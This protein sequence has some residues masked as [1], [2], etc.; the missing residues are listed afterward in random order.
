MQSQQSS[1][2]YVDPKSNVVDYDGSP[3]LAEEYEERVW[4]GFQKDEKASYAAK[5]KNALH[6]RAWTLR[7]RKP[8]IAAQKLSQI[9][10][11][12]PSAN[13]GPKAAVQLVVK[14]V[15]SACEKVAPLL[16]TQTFEDYF[17]DK[18]RRKL[19][20]SIQD[21]ISRREGE[22]E[23]LSALTQGHT[24]LSTDLQAFL[25]LRN[26]GV[27]PSQHRAILGQ[28]GNEYDWDKIVEAMLIQ[29]DGGEEPQGKG[30]K[31]N[32]KSR[33]QSNYSPGGKRSWA[34]P[35]EEE[36]SSYEGETDEIYAVEDW[37]EEQVEDD[38]PVYEVEED[39][40]YDIEEM[41]HAIEVMTV[42]D[43]SFD[44]LDVFAATIQ[45]MGKGA[46]ECSKETGSSR[47][48]GQSRI[49]TW[50]H[51]TQSN[52]HCPGWKAD[53]QCWSTTRQAATDQSKN[54]ML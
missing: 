11:A 29:L 19:G 49:S 26:A 16:K 30:W 12:E 45:R 52:G 53:P 47:W 14:T 27:S 6:G 39:I 36:W 42:E 13:A 38:I 25:L 9:S 35:I 5:L 32:Y 2:L 10:E 51:W 40:Q 54:P 33:Q 18:G 15:R 17:F 1:S 34:F 28:A 43:L 50:C 4:L 41:E 8:E 46:S 31:G 7:H 37:Q 48:Q 20:E 21:Y 3:K 23:K 24:K 44:E 22:Y